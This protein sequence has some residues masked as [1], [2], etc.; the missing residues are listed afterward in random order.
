M[1]TVCSRLISRWSNMGAFKIPNWGIFLNVAN[2]WIWYYWQ[3]YKLRHTLSKTG[4][5]KYSNKSYLCM[6]ITS[7]LNRYTLIQHIWLWKHDFTTQS[8]TFSWARFNHST[9]RS[10]S[11]VQFSFEFDFSCFDQCS[12]TCLIYTFYAHHITLD[13]IVVP[14]NYFCWSHPITNCIRSLIRTKSDS[15]LYHQHFDTW[16]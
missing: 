11:F 14:N 16:K 10:F 12:R 15:S 8:L 4:P 6:A 1:E 7:Q 5:I 13:R 9:S 3:L 2:V